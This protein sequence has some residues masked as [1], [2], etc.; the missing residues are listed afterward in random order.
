MKYFKRLL[1]EIDKL[2]VRKNANLVFKRIVPSTIIVNQMKFATVCLLLVLG[3]GIA[4]AAVFDSQLSK[5]TDFVAIASTHSVGAPKPVKKPNGDAQKGKKLRLQSRFLEVRQGVSNRAYRAAYSSLNKLKKSKID[6]DYKLIKTFILK[7]RKA[8]KYAQKNGQKLTP[9]EKAAVQAE[10]K[11]AF[12][13][14][15]PKKTAKKAKLTLAQKQAA[16]QKLTSAQR[17]KKTVTRIRME[18]LADKG[19]LTWE[20]LIRKAQDRLKRDNPK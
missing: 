9:Q 19:R 16:W 15:I 7:N 14:K 5:F 3:A 18:I 17:V 1:S 2:S 4:N 12:T 6:A 20:T 13:I 11:K 8:A 10:L